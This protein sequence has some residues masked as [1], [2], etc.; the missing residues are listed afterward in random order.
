M[1]AV[2]LVALGFMAACS[3]PEPSFDERYAE[4]QRSIVATGAAIDGEIKAQEDW[5]AAE[6]AAAKAPPSAAPTEPR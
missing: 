3:K 1:R 6:D 5:R 4:A 2:P